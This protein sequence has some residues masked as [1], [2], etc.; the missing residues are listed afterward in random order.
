LLSKKGVPFE[1]VDVTLDDEKRNWLFKTTGQ[2][3]V[4]Q[5]FINGQALGGFDDM[6][7]LDRKGELDRLLD[8]V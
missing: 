5:I 2:R 6:C 7:A 4:P 1:E 8:G 3:T